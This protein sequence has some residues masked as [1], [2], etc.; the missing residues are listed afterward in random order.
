MALDAAAL[1][2]GTYCLHEIS[3]DVEGEVVVAHVDQRT[4]R[5]PGCEPLV[6]VQ[7]LELTLRSAACDSKLGTI[8]DGI[9]RVGNLTTVFTARREGLR[10]VHSADFYW[11]PLAGGGIGAGTLQGITPT[12][13]SSG[14]QRRKPANC[15]TT[16]AS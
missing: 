1:L 3:K 11:K 16:R 13:A 12:P 8:L 7:R 10:G 2:N 15:A 14:R 5:N 9:M 4:C 6:L